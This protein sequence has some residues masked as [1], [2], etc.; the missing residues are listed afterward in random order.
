VKVTYRGPC[1]EMYGKEI[2]YPDHECTE[3]VVH[4]R[5]QWT[6]THGL[7]CGPYEQWTEEYYE[8]SIC[9]QQIEVHN[10]DNQG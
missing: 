3:H 2:E 6:E 7:E 4:R 10:D 9:G 8:C 5:E 1:E